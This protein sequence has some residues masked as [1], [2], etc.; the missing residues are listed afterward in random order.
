MRN[1]TLDNIVRG[2]LMDSGYPIHWYIEFLNYGTS[3]VRELNYDVLQNIKSIRLSVNSYKAA[4][5]PCDFVDYTRVGTEDGQYINPWAE[6][7]SSFNRLNKFE[8]GNKVA[9]GNV[10]YDNYILPNNYE[11]FWYSTYTNWYGEHLGRIFN[12]IDQNR[13]SFVILRERGEIQLDQSFSGDEITMDYVSDGL[14]TDA[15]NLIHP[16][17]VET[18][19]AYIQWKRREH[20]RH[21]NRQ[22]SEL[23]KQEY[24]NQ[25]RMLR[26]RM[27]NIDVQEIKRS[28][29][30]Y[31]IPTIKY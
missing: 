31:T 18:I 5:L 19:K 30:R 27:N 24:Y 21:Y 11:T 13:N 3:A 6:K 22:E 15:S 1:Y 29:R 25:L 2:A 17:A 10:E 4:K 28:L 8:D 14:T 7:R 16:Y 9:Y 26:A 20:G 23:A 12:H